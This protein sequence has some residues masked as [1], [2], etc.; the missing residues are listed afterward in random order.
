MRGRRL[1]LG[2]M[3]VLVLLA[4]ADE[5]S[6]AQ[7]FGGPSIV[8][9]PIHHAQTVLVHIEALAQTVAQLE[10]LRDMIENSLKAGSPSWGELAAILDELDATLQSGQAIAYSLGDLDARFRGAFPGYDPADDYAGLYQRWSGTLLDTLRGTL[11]AS[12]VNARDARTVDEVLNV[13][14]VR[15]RRAAGRMQAL[16]IGNALSSR[17]I[18]ELAKLR[19]LVAAS[20]NAQNVYLATRESREAAAVSSLD[21]FLGEP[22]MV[23]PTDPENDVRSFRWPFEGGPG[24]RGLSETNGGLR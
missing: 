11:V 12:G 13:L 17:T 5:P 16:Q 3:V 2:L 24:L 23:I 6:Q 14:R 8:Y 19:Q 22:E 1:R 18:E 20:T 7:F 10:M 21:R 4:F 9:D 15:N